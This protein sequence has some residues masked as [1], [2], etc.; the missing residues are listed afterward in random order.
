MAPPSCWRS[1]PA[2]WTVLST[3]KRNGMADSHF[4][5][6]ATTWPAMAGSWLGASHWIVSV[7]RG[8]GG[9]TAESR[10]IPVVAGKFRLLW[11]ATKVDRR[12]QE[13]RRRV[14]ADGSLDAHPALASK[15]CRAAVVGRL[16][17]V[18][19]GPPTWRSGPSVRLRQ[20]AG[21]RSQVLPHVTAAGRPPAGPSCHIPCGTGDTPEQWL[22]APVADTAAPRHLRRPLVLLCWPPPAATRPGGVRQHPT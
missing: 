19:A 20:T 4:F 7:V 15:S 13:R 16:D 6:G 14:R 1:T 2:A 21:R 9:Q 22:T 3:S 10:Q 12:G 17:P 5:V 11:G 18:A 8:K